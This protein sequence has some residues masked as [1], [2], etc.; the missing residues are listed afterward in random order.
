MDSDDSAW[1]AA[2]KGARQAAVG[3]ESESEGGRYGVEPAKKRRRKQSKKEVVW[4]SD[5]SEEEDGMRP[6]EGISISGA[7]ERAKRS[8]GKDARDGDGPSD[9]QRERVDKRREY[10][11]SKGWNRASED[12]E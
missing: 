10:W 9:A 12:T 7:S 2:D 4:V 6:K 8:A 3:S 1:E 5:E 11:R